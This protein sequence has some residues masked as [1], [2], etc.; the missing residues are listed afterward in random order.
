MI[1]RKYSP[2]ELMFHTGAAASHSGEEVCDLLM[3]G[4]PQA[5]PRYP[6]ALAD[7][8]DDDY[9]AGWRQEPLLVLNHVV[10]CAG[11][12]KSTKDSSRMIRLSLLPRVRDQLV[13]FWSVVRQLPVGLSGFTRTN[14]STRSRN[15][16]INSSAP[17]VNEVGRGLERHDPLARGKRFRYSSNVGTGTPT[18]SPPGISSPIAQISSAAP[19]PTTIYSPGHTRTSSLR[20]APAPLGGGGVVARGGAQGSA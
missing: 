10:Q 4:D 8:L 9:G 13:E 14:V 6:I 17:R 5:R 7:A 18:R 15:L 20:G 2:N 16:S 11:S 1:W 3:P 12:A 19:L